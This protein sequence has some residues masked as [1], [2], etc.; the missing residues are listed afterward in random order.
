[1]RFSTAYSPQFGQANTT[2]T[3]FPRSYSST[4]VERVKG[5]STHVTANGIQ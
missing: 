5:A 2:Q 1:M 3:P 4:T